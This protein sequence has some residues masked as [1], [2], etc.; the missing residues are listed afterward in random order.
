M[1]HGL[2]PL[3]K[4]FYLLLPACLIFTPKRVLPALVLCL[5]VLALFLRF[6][7]VQHEREFAAYVLLPC[8]WDSLFVG[9]LFAWV[10]KTGVVALNF[11]FTDDTVIVGRSIC[12]LAD[13]HTCLA[14]C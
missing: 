14:L 5:T 10:Y 11:F 7:F 4:Q 3:R 8:R 13:G 6:C 1:F 9:V 2:L 12:S